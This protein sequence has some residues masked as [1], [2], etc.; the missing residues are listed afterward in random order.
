M[1]NVAANQHYFDI[2]ANRYEELD[3]RRTEQL[4]WWLDDNLG[5][6]VAGKTDAALLD[7]GCG[8]GFIIRRAAGRFGPRYGID[9]SLGML[10]QA[11]ERGFAVAQAG[12]ARL[13]FA[14]ESFD[15]VT[16]L[17]VLHHLETH[18]ETFAEVYRV[19]RPGGRFYSDHDLCDDF[20]KRF[21]MPLYFYRKIFSMKR[22]YLAADQRL[23]SELYDQTEFHEEGLDSKPLIEMLRCV[24]FRKVEVEYH[25]RGLSPVFNKLSTMMGHRTGSVWRGF[26]PSFAL[27]AEK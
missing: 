9:I 1:E 15:A 22:R 23:T 21:A 7:I 18:E 14:S 3:G 19:L 12:C 4:S 24:G 5:R 8:T 10:K 16:A 27:W 13:P 20:A 17:A 25:W 2:I 6:L 26:A 11:R